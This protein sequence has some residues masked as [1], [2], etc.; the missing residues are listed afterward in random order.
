LNLIGRLKNRG[1]EVHLFF[2]W[3]PDVE[4]ALRRAKERVS[5]GGHDVPE[6]VVRRRFD[7]SVT[8]FLACY[9]Q[10]ADSWTLFDNS[11]AIPEPIAFENH[12]KVSIMDA[13]RYKKLIAQYE[14]K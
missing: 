9:R 13:H 14:E 3:V 2:L 1:Y 7:R 4:F 6:S 11:G 12:G 10:S 5:R 8:N